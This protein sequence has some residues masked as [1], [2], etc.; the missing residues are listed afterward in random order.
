M[1]NNKSPLLKNSLELKLYLAN[2]IFYALHFFL[3]CFQAKGKVEAIWFVVAVGEYNISEMQ[4]SDDGLNAET[5][6]QEK[7]KKKQK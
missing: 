7:K 2:E 5:L 3:L 6:I 4:L 1:L